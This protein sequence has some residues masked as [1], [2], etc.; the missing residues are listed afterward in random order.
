MTET[1][2]LNFCFKIT[3]ENVLKLLR[4]VMAFC[5]LKELHPFHWFKL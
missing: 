2:M 1:K 4:A 5:D 3:R